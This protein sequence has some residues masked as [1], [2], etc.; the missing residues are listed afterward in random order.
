MVFPI[1]D[2]N[3]DRRI[4]P[5]INYALIGINVFVFVVFQGMGANDKFT[6]KFATVPAE[7]KTGKDLV[8]DDRVVTDPVSGQRFTAPG[9]QPTPWPVYLTLLTSMFMHGGIAHLLGNMWFLYIFGD[10]VEDRMGHG[11]YL[12]FYLLTGII[13]SLSHVVMNLNGP[14]SL[15]PSLGASG[16]ISGVMGAYLA[17]CPS[18][19]VQVLM[20][21]VVTEIPGYMAVGLWFLFQLVS[22]MG[23]LG[24]GSEGDGVAYAAHVGG[25]VAGVLLARPF[26]FGREQTQQFRPGS[27]YG[28]R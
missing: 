19:R 4:V 17:L 27:Q 10:N 3:S 9:L 16:A 28:A 5:A 12:A 7:I 8:T 14:S 22:G 24:G 26:L 20:L 1:S 25:F 23:L 15:I 18:R 13:A 6:Y 11:R 2:D 21:R